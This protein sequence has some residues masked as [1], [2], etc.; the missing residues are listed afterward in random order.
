MDHYQLDRDREAILRRLERLEELVATS[1]SASTARSNST[2]PRS[3]HPPR[4]I[5]SSSHGPAVR[6]THDG[7][8]DFLRWV[9]AVP[10]SRRETI[11][12]QIAAVAHDDAV[13]DALMHEL[14]R[15][16]VR[17]FGRHL[18]LLSVLGE[19]RHPRAVESLKHF[20]HLPGAA[21]VPLE[22][23]NTV[24]HSSRVDYPA[25]LQARAV[26]MLA[27]MRTPQAL[28][29]VSII[30][31]EHNSRVVRIAALDAYAFNH[32]DHPTAVE[33]ARRMARPEEA[34]LVGL[35]RRTRD[36]DPADF[37]ARVRA[38]VDRHP[39]DR[40]PAP[41]QTAGAPRGKRQVRPGYNEPTL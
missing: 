20:I 39:E 28:E 11:R 24:A 4:F 8:E 3:H 26:E 37:D 1:P 25:A 22:E 36:G 12:E 38:F 17:D 41:Q 16:P 9:A 2:P 35:P 34:M 27:Y 5:S 15:L 7:I 18:M 31:S 23:N 10:V 13:V 19:T 30:A 21:I 29:M 40:P 14:H 6:L 33:R 32:D